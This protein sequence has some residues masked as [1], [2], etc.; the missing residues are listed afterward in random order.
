MACLG[1][2]TFQS[3]TEPTRGAPFSGRRFATQGDRKVAPPREAVGHASFFKATHAGEMWVMLK[4][5]FRFR[6]HV[7]HVPAE[8][9]VYIGYFRHPADR[10]CRIRAVNRRSQR[11]S[12]VII[13]GL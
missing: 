7:R 12:R 10:A 6:T 3:L 9:G 4:P 2:A 13:T 1:A 11:P 8:L 5:H